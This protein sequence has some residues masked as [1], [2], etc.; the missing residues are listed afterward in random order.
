MDREMTD[1]SFTQLHREALCAHRA[2]QRAHI[3]KQLAF[4]QLRLSMSEQQYKTL[5]KQE[6]LDDD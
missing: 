4:A 1:N 3:E 5:L 2:M 6:G